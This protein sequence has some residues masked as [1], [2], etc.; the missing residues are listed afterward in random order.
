MSFIE[1]ISFEATPEFQAD[2][3]LS[4]SVLGKI[5]A[6]DGVIGIY[7]GFVED[8]PTRCYL[9]IVWHSESLSLPNHPTIFDDFKLL[10][11]TPPSR[12][13]VTLTDN[14]G[15]SI[16]APVTE[17]LSL[18][19]KDGCSYKDLD[20]IMNEFSKDIHAGKVEGAFFPC[21]W[22][23][24]KDLR[25]SEGTGTLFLSFAG[26]TKTELHR[27]FEAKMHALARTD[28]DFGAM[29]GR[30]IAMVEDIKVQHVNYKKHF[31]N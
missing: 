6:L 4:N 28:P 11:L 30:F 13:Q 14:I 12:H 20:E 31:R 17:V 26:W 18:V 25:T 27:A 5:G 24:A 1:S 7:Q 15:P 10:A 16:D 3:S 22:G 2:R 29:F 21:V 8:D 9:A 19:L 23:L